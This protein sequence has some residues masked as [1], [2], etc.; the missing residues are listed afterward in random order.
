MFVPILQLFIVDIRNILT[1]Y[2]D[3]NVTEMMLAHSHIQK[4]ET[5]AIPTSTRILSEQDGLE[6]IIL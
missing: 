2:L 1:S 5:A 6:Q 4:S 3:V